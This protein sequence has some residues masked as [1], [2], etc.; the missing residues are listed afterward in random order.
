[1]TA[2][3]R[4]LFTVTYGQDE[5]PRRQRLL[6]LFGMAAV[7]VILAGSA[8]VYL[9]PIGKHTYTALLTESGAVRPGEDVRVAGISVG[10]V[11]SL[12]LLDDSV[13]LTFT[14][15]TKVF[16]GDMTSIEVRMLTPI[17]GH[18][19][20]LFPAGKIALGAKSIP[21]ERVRLPYSLAQAVADAQRPL[22]TVDAVTLRRNVDALAAGLERSPDSLGAA[23]DGMSTL[24]GLLDKQNTDIRR[25]LDTASEYLSTLTD[26]RSIIGAMLTKIGALEGQVLGRKADLVEAL[27]VT[28]ELLARIAAVEPAW[29]DQLEPLAD[30][31]L[32]AAPQ[33]RE[34]GGKLGAVAD[35]LGQAGDRLRALA[36]PD[37]LEV[38]QSG[39]TV[40]ARPICVPVPGREC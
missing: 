35:G 5:T 18:Y 33:L 1:M 22:Q 26:T 21:V 17:G 15:D 40:A 31:L 10:S 37:G 38:D 2:V 25:A 4:W 30:R 8:I 6:G 24:V 32:A 12:E 14:A 7:A 36:G 9:V 23:I 3:L 39:H 19:L 11:R 34:L 29:R 28:G 27:R 13:R 16:L 20:A